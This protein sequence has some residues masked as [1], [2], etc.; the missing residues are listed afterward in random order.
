MRPPET[1]VC[2][3][4]W[5]SRGYVF[6]MSSISTVIA[7]GGWPPTRPCRMEI[8]SRSGERIQIWLLGRSLQQMGDQVSA[9][10]S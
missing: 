6:L 3:A 1:V 7:V 4:S 5:S 2:S 9:R 8:N 10:A